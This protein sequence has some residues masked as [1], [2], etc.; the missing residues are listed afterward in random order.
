[1]DREEI[2]ENKLTHAYL[3]LSVPLTCVVPQTSI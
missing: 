2:I 1:M 3:S